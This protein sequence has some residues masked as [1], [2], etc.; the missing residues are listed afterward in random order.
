MQAFT[1]TTRQA[2]ARRACAGPRRLRPEVRGGER[3]RVEELRRPATLVEPV[4]SPARPRRGRPAGRRFRSA[5]PRART[6]PFH[7]PRR[8]RRSARAEHTTVWVLSVTWRRSTSSRPR[9]ENGSSARWLRRLRRRSSAGPIARGR[10]RARPGADRLGEDARGLP[11][12]HRPAQRHAGRGAAT[13]LLSP[14]KALNYD[15]ERNLRGPL[16]GLDSKLRVGVRDRSDW[17][18]G[19][20]ACGAMFPGRAGRAGVLSHGRG[21]ARPGP[22]GVPRRHRPVPAAERAVPGGGR[23]RVHGGDR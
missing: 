10:A 19:E 11:H 20:E 6:R 8:R 12:R 9:R 15:I 13:A 16:A 2:P 14:L 22:P 21:D 5:S 4:R 17:R 1:D 23:V 7:H 18:D 3:L